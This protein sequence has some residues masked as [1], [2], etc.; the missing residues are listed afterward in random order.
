ML[1]IRPIILK[2]SR[3][4][5]KLS[6]TKRAGEGGRKDSKDGPSD[7]GPK[8]NFSFSLG[9]LV[10][11]PSSSRPPDPKDNIHLG[12]DA[13]DRRKSRGHSGDD[14]AASYSGDQSKQSAHVSNR[15]DVWMI[16]LSM[17]GKR[18]K[19]LP[20]QPHH[21]DRQPSPMLELPR[22]EKRRVP[23]GIEGIQKKSQSSSD[24]LARTEDQ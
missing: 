21:A 12:E 15:H 24:Y 7:K 16:S 17:I 13:L 9:S 5:A 10:G 11:G 22:S 19:L 2:A 23:K 3:T 18:K 4:G 1:E 14:G 8:Y 20:I 6:G